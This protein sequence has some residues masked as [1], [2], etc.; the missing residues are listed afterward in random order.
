MSSIEYSLFRTRFIRPAQTTIFSSDLTPVQIFLRALAEKKSARLRKDHIWH[1]GNIRH[2][3]NTTGYFAIGRTTTS[4]IEKY[5]KETGNFVAEELESSPYTHGVFDAEIGFV[6]IAK[7]SSLTPTTKGIAIRLQQLLSLAEI[8]EV[9]G[10]SVEIS[11]IPDPDGF[12]RSLT[13]AHRV[14]NFTATFHGPNPF[15]ADEH[16]QKPLSV[17]L[18]AAR[19]KKGRTVIQGDDLDRDVLQ[20]ITRSTAATGNEAKARIIKYRT[21]RPITINLSGDPIKRRYDEQD[22]PELVLADLKNLYQKVRHA[23]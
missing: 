5:N 2:F 3:S 7:K 21:Q 1:I 13:A 4:T 17:Y 9:N 12:V 19:G 6:G 22:D 8:V 14:I 23:R 18:A 16:F 15:D 10:I 20:G 11:P